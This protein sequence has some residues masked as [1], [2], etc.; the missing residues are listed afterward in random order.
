MAASVCGSHSAGGH[1]ADRAA[2]VQ[3]VVVCS[4][5]SGEGAP[6]EAVADVEERCVQ[7]R[8]RGAGSRSVQ[9]GPQ[10]RI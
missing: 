7:S 5:Q 6:S 10:P 9:R 2:L 8:M 3:D 4:V 1:E